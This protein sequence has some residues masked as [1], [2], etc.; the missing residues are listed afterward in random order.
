MYYEDTTIDLSSIYSNNGSILLLE[1][2]LEAKGAKLI[3]VYKREVLVLELVEEDNESIQKR[4]LFAREKVQRIS[5]N[6]LWAL[7]YYWNGIR[8]KR[9]RTTATSYFST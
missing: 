1:D 5:S 2:I 6:P 7:G 9:R 3:L 8:I 4:Y